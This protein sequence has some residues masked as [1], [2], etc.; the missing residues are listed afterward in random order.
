MKNQ[1]LDLKEISNSTNEKKIQ[2]TQIVQM[3]KF[4]LIFGDF[5]DDHL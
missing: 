1:Y 2:F 4:A 5:Y 3:Q